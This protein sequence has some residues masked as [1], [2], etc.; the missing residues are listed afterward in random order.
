MTQLSEREKCL[1]KVQEYGF[2]LYDVSLFLDTH[3]TDKN[4]LDFFHKM[5]KA[6]KEA[7]DNYVSRYGP[8]NMYA[9]DNERKW[10]W[11]DDPWPW[12][13]ED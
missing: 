8:L 2:A 3:P 4:A 7:V 13:M 6:Q 9:V 1:K 11:V 10:T 12:D 5:K